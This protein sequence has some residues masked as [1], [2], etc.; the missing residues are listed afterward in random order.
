MLR[1]STTLLTDT[2]DNGVCGEF[3]CRSLMIIISNVLWCIDKASEKSL[4]LNEWVRFPLSQISVSSPP[5][6]SEEMWAGSGSVVVILDKDAIH[7]LWH[8]LIKSAKDQPH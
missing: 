8:Q 1:G 3:F 6:T 4:C 2:S 7:F 5:M